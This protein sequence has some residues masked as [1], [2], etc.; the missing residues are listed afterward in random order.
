MVFRFTSVI[1]LKN[2]YTEHFILTAVNVHIYLRQLEYCESSYIVNPTKL[3]DRLKIISQRTSNTS[4]S[5]VR[6]KN[7][8]ILKYQN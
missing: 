1:D 3:S 2:S 5:L 4:V 8:Y 7:Q 6:E